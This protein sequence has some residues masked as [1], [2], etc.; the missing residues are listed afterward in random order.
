VFVVFCNSGDFGNLAWGLA[1]NLARRAKFQA[2]FQAT[3]SK[4]PE[5]Q[6]MTKTVRKGFS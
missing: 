4:L 6:T 5:L 3:F 1:R 2:K